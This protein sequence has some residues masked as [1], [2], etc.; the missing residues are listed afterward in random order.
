MRQRR[1][2]AGEDLHWSR[3]P[4]PQ[5]LSVQNRPVPIDDYKILLR[6][7]PSAAASAIHQQPIILFL[8][9]SS[10][11]ASGAVE[12]I[13]TALAP[14]I[15]T[16]EVDIITEMLLPEPLLISD[17]GLSEIPDI[18][19]CSNEMRNDRR[20]LCT[21]AV[22]IA[23]ERCDASG[24]THALRKTKLRLYSDLSKNR[25]S[26]SRRKDKQ[27]LSS[28]RIKILYKHNKHYLRLSLNGKSNVH[29]RWN[30]D[31]NLYLHP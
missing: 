29:A 20:S 14:N 30:S 2:S 10:T 13:R 28:V 4:R 7:L 8:L 15:S 3:Y 27:P 19:K 5:V 17:I 22:E 23:R 9:N 31:N 24:L 18:E 26:T 11:V 6:T 16:A 25:I 1:R 12:Y 21:L